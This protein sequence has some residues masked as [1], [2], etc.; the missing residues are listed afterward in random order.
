MLSLEEH[1]PGHDAKGHDASILF[2]IGIV[3]YLAAYCIMPVILVNHS[4][5]GML[6]DIL[7]VLYVF[8]S[9]ICLACYF[10]LVIRSI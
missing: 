8:L 5:D 2:D 3:L 10:F 6:V 7:M 9:H 1:C 4:V